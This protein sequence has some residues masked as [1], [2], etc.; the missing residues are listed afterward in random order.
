MI[1]LTRRRLLG[2]AGASLA[3]GAAI[4]PS[5]VRSEQRF[6]D[7]DAPWAGPHGDRR[8]LASRPSVTAPAD[9]TVE[10]ERTYARGFPSGPSLALA[11]DT[12]VVGGESA[13]YGLDPVDGA[14]RWS[15]SLPETFPGRG[16]GTRLRLSPWLADDRAVCVFDTDVCAV[17]LSSGRLQWRVRTNASVDATLVTGNT[18]LVAGRRSGTRGLWALDARQASLGGPT[19]RP[20]ARGGRSP[21]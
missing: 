5:V 17:S 8:G 12:L 11:A 15:Y 16:L 19:P 20:S 2:L 18:A 1:R 21:H 4:R 14:E 10:W 3:I 6:D 9:V 7:A 13:L